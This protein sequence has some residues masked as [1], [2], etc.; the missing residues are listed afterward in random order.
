MSG[1]TDIWIPL[2]SGSK[3]P[4]ISKYPDFKLSDCQS[5]RMSKYPDIKLSGYQII[6][7]SKYPDVKG[8]GYQ[9]LHDIKVSGYKS[10]HD[11]FFAFYFA[12][13]Y[14]FQQLLYCKFHN[15]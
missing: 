1:C 12:N 11:N 15:E 7:L 10:L 3:Y 4:R 14:I 13:L 8:S 6:K 5:I 9:S 2:F